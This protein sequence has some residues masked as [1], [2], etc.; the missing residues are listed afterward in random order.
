MDHL[1]CAGARDLSRAR[2]HLSAMKIF[3]PPGMRQVQ[4]LL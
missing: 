3:Q 4:G 1:N 2:P